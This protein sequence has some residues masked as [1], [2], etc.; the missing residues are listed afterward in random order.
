M[1]QALFWQKVSLRAATE[2]GFTSIWLIKFLVT[3]ETTH[4]PAKHH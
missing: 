2:H 1:G 4:I 3:D